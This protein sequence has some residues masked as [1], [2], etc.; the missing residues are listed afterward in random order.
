MG[1]QRWTS[2]VHQLCC[3]PACAC[4][5]DNDRL[6]LICQQISRGRRMRQHSLFTVHS[7]LHAAFIACRVGA[8][9]KLNIF[10]ARDAQRIS[11]TLGLDNSSRR[12]RNHYDSR[13]TFQPWFSWTS[14]RSILLKSYDRP[15][16]VHARNPDTNASSQALRHCCSVNTLCTMPFFYHIFTSF[17]IHLQS[18]ILCVFSLARNMECFILNIKR[19]QNWKQWNAEKHRKQNIE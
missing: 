4:H 5:G 6:W 13:I 7:R 16:R 2:I 8:V 1:A 17:T 11:Q 9:P 14:K 3:I 10:C 12:C 19:S 18:A 15:E